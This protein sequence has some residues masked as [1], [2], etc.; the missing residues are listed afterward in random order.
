MF[1]LYL[2]A[3]LLTIFVG[4]RDAAGRN[5]KIKKT[6][7]YVRSMV[8]SFCVGQIML[9]FLFA[10][11]YSMEQ[12]DISIIEVIA[13]RCFLPF[14]FYI[15]IV[16]MT[17]I[18]YMIPNWE[19]KSLVTVLVFGPLTSIQPIVILTTMMYALQSIDALCCTETCFVYMGCFLCLF[20]EKF[21]G[22][23]EWSKNDV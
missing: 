11:A 19:I 18:P 17:F 14:S 12:F 9:G 8:R 10:C 2:C 22:W 3:T 5:A 13:Q 21:L 7:Y 20:F 4:F 23:T 15:A 1:F 16:L 6:S